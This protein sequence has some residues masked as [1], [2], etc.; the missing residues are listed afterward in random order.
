VLVFFHR[1]RGDRA[2]QCV[3]AVAR[4]QAKQSHTVVQRRM[5]GG[6]FAWHVFVGSAV[7][8]DWLAGRMNVFGEF[9]GLP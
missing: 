8:T 5:P 9:G 4:Q 2:D 3:F 6:R 7:A 1:K